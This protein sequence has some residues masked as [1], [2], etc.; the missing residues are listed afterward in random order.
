MLNELIS[1]VLPDQ[2]AATGIAVI[3]L[4][5][6]GLAT[7][8]GI[9]SQWQSNPVRHSFATALHSG[10]ARARLQND[11]SPACCHL[12][13]EF[14]KTPP[15]M[16]VD[17]FFARYFGGKI[18]ANLTNLMAFM[19]SQPLMRVWRMTASLVNLSAAKRGGG[20]IGC[21]LNHAI[22]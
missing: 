15:E 18:D 4:T 16:P 3:G 8:H 10:G 2:R 5:I 22:D 11:Q 14:L 6:V 21:S 7:S 13:R 17:A 12:T 1:T 20:G 9:L 19:Q